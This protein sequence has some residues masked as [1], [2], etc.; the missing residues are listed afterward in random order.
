[1]RSLRRAAQVRLTHINRAC[2]GE[3]RDQRRLFCAEVHIFFVH[4]MGDELVDEKRKK[5]PNDRD[6]QQVVC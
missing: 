3:V 4:E 2:G 6:N 5:F 1:M